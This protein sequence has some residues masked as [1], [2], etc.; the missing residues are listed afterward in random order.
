L[1]TPPHCNHEAQTLCPS[2]DHTMDHHKSAC[3][4]ISVSYFNLL[5]VP[6][7]LCNTSSMTP[8]LF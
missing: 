3:S 4:L 7:I 1:S 5:F 6:T 2:H 8:S